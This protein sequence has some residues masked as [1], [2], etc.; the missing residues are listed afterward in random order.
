[1]LFVIL[2]SMA[3]GDTH[4][5]MSGVF[6]Q[7]SLHSIFMVPRIVTR[8]RWEPTAKPTSGQLDYALFG[9]SAVREQHIE[10]MGLR[11]TALLS[12]SLFLMFLGI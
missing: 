10:G 3:L 8:L 6:G 5:H 12:F 7:A 4:I 11:E 9:P 1:M 2:I